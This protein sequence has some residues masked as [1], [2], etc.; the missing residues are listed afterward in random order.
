M[1]PP[2]SQSARTNPRQRHIP[3]RRRYHGLK[4]AD[5]AVLSRSA[6][7]IT[8]AHCPGKASNLAP[9][10]L[11]CLARE[12][13]VGGTREG[14]RQSRR[15]PG[16][17]GEPGDVRAEGSAAA[18]EQPRGRNPAT[19]AKTW[20]TSRPRGGIQWFVQAP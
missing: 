2:D 4:P 3:H 14:L 13:I 17:D 7:D 19:A 5:G 1:V 11:A 15:W 12:L 20:K 8:G 9:C 10:T 18:A 16:T 6:R